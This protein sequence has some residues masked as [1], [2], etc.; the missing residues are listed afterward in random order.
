MNIRH[1]AL[2]DLERLYQ[3]EKRCFQNIESTPKDKLKER[4]KNLTHFYVLEESNRIM[5][6]IAGISF[7][8]PFFSSSL[9]QST[10]LDARKGSDFFLLTLTCDKKYQHCGYGSTLLKYLENILIKENKQHIYLDCKENRIMFYSRFHYNCI[11][12]TKVKN[13]IW[14]EMKKDIGGKK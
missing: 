12:Q 7:D 3:I 6:Y 4:I 13:Q 14:Y 10:K 2:K 11:K 8:E 5:A 9:Y 1:A